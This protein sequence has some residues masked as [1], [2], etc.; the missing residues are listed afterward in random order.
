MRKIAVLILS[1]CVF[2]TAKSQQNNTLFLMRDLPQNNIVNPASSIKCGWYLGIPAIASTHFNMYSSGFSAND[3]ISTNSNGQ[4]EFTPDDAI[5]KMNRREV[6]AAELH[7]NL[8]YFGYKYNNNYFTF[9]L[10]EKVNTYNIYSQKI[11]MLLNDGNS[12]FE[13]ENV[14][15]DGTRVNANHYREYAFGWANDVNEDLSIG[16]KVKFLFGKGNVY[17]TPTKA[18]LRVDENTFAN[19][20]VTS[21]EANLSFPARIETDADGYITDFTLNDDV[22]WTDYAMNNSNFGLGFDLGLIYKLDESTTLSASL[23]DMGFI[24]WASDV[25]MVSIDANVTIDGADEDLTITDGQE[26]RDSLMNL[27]K[28]V[29]A[30]GSYVSSLKPTF[31]AGIDRQIN[32]TVNLGLMISSEIYQNRL[33][34]ALGISGNFHITDKLSASAS[35]IIQN[36]EFNNFGAGIGWQLGVLYFHAVSDNIPAFL[37]LD[38]ARNINLRFGIGILS[39]CKE[40]NRNRAKFDCVG[41]PYHSVHAPRKR[42]HRYQKR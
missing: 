20:V 29:I 14:N 34:N 4:L 38:D 13:G 16:C 25:Q 8:L 27:F 3:V 39:G 35:Y 33:H 6:L 30:N 7:L 37:S 10:S 40:K 21:G 22:D 31:Y 42:A 26:I 17:S 2:L 18:Q 11:A 36:N 12:Q 24:D 28:P 32:K 23:L 1:I 9:S 41:D 19:Q 5:S 15:M